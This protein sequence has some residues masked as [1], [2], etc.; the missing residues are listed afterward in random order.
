MRE[1]R[2]LTRRLSHA[3]RMF[4]TVIDAQPLGLNWRIVHYQM[5]TRTCGAGR[6]APN[7]SQNIKR[8]DDA[9]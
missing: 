6:D 7:H 8:V 1:I 2:N 9:I 5:I 3:E 4:Q